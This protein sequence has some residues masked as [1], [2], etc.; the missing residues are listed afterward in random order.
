MAMVLLL[1]S[2]FLLVTFGLMLALGRGA[3][4]VSRADAEPSP[5]HR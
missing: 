4:G 2:V 3:S 1:L 5:V